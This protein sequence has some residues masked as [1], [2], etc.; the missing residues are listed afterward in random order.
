MAIRLIVDPDPLGIIA[1]TEGIQMPL[2]DWRG[3][4][5][6][7]MTIEQVVRLYGHPP[8]GGAALVSCHSEG[9]AACGKSHPSANT[10]GYPPVD[11]SDLSASRDVCEK[12]HQ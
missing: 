9:G 12:M 2:S 11:G 1:D 8:Q 4:A 5:R 10:Q 6:L 7:G 3:I